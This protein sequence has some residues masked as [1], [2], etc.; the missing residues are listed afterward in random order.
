M[1]LITNGR[2][3]E[4]TVGYRSCWNL[5]SSGNLLHDS[6]CQVSPDPGTFLWAN[7]TVSFRQFCWEPFFR[8]RAQVGHFSHWGLWFLVSVERRSCSD[9]GDRECS[10]VSG[11]RRAWWCRGICM[12]T[13]A[14]EKLIEGKP[15][16]ELFWGSHLIFDIPS[17]FFWIN[18]L[19]SSGIGEL[20]WLGFP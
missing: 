7:S 12:R 1:S 15:K 11:P 6:K 17:R 3:S 9:W 13:W 2:M 18:K 5:P 19:K 10:V 14:V 16:L 8:K 4:F 20:A